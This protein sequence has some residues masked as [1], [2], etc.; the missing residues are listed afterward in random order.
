MARPE[1]HNKL[2]Q[3]QRISRAFFFSENDG[4]DVS[5]PWQTIDEMSSRRNFWG[6]RRCPHEKRVK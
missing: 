2:T 1:I 4:H 3:V 6:R 5:H